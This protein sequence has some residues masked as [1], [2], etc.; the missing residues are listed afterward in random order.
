M[1]NQLVVFIDLLGFSSIIE[2]QDDVRYEQIHSLLTDL[3]KTR[4]DFRS[5]TRCIDAGKREHEIRPAISTFSD[6]IVISIPTEGQG[7]VGAGPIVISL[8]EFVAGNIFSHAIR[9]GCLVRGGIAFGGLHHQGGVG[10]RT[11]LGP[12]L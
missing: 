7:L 5:D 4:G 11:G 2:T 10:V 3:A 6:L 8:A 1:D 12:G 9:F